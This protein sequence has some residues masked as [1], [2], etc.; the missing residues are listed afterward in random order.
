[1]E[2][3]ITEVQT[4]GRFADFIPR[5]ADSGDDGCRDN[6]R[7]SEAIHLLGLPLLVCNRP[8]HLAHSEGMGEHKA[9]IS[10]NL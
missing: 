5:Q 9:K 7:G 10:R 8:L 6:E 2:S 3:M 4:R 1:M